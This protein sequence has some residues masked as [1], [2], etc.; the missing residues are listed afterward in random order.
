MTVQFKTVFLE[1]P[2]KVWGGAGE[3]RSIT[4]AGF[5]TESPQI[6]KFLS[7]LKFTTDEA[8]QFYYD[9]DKKNLELSAIA[10]A[11]ITANPDKVKAFVAGVESADGKPAESVVLP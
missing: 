11:W 5:G 8:G 1:D 6:T 7:N 3:I 9:H 10:E 4:R 2:E